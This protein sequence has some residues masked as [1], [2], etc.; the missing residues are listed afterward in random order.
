MISRS[1]ATLALMLCL[2]MFAAP[3][4]AAADA[5]AEKAPTP[6]RA[7]ISTDYPPV[8][9]KKDGLIMGIEAD[10]A[11]RLPGEL[12]MP[13][14]K[15]EVAWDDLIPALREKRIDVI[16]SGMSI[17][18]GRARLVEFTEPYLRV[19]QMAV[20]L[21]KNL[22]RLRDYDVMELPSTRVGYQVNTTGESYA[23]K[24]LARAQLKGY[25]TS[26]AGIAALRAG[27]IDY[28]VHDAPTIWRLTGGF[29]SVNDDLAGRYRPL[30]TEYLAWA[31]RKE[32]TALEKKLNGVLRR[33]ESGGVIDSILDRWIRVRKVTIEVAPPR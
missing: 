19:G 29:D 33:W 2:T 15:V 12:S 5:E 10:F 25:D 6:L 28:F 13:V 30:T 17:T 3:R 11:D 8:A 32:D 27:E 1:E 20:V 18:A 24:S 31:V 26:A 7:G 14:E 22:R 9:F 21:A 16:M 23:R 4:E